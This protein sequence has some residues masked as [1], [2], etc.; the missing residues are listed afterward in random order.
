MNEQSRSS[1]DGKL[2]L[3][4]LLDPPVDSCLFVEAFP[5]TAIPSAIDTFTSSTIGDEAFR[6]S[7]G[8]GTVLRMQR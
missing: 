2:P 7:I 6:F 3:H 1:F 5:V 4:L 8:S